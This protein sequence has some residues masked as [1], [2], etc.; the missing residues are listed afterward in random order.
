VPQGTWYAEIHTL[1]AF[2]SNARCCRIAPVKIAILTKG[3]A[4]DPFTAAY[5][6]G[7]PFTDDDQLLVNALR[8]RGHH[9]VAV[10]WDTALEQ[11]QGYDLLL[12][13]S[14][15]DFLFRIDLFRSWLDV[16]L[17][18]ALPI[19]NPIATVRQNLSK[20][21][22]AT[23]QTGGATIIP[24]LFFSPGNHAR[25]AHEARAFG[26]Q[27]VVLKPAVSGGALGAVRHP[28]GASAAIEHAATEILTPG[29]LIV[30]P[31]FEEIGRQGEWSLVFFGSEFSHAV[32]KVPKPG[33]F[34][35]QATYGGSVVRDV[36]SS[37]LIAQAHRAREILASNLPYCRVDGIERAGQL[38]INEVELIDPRLFFATHP[39]AAARFATVLEKR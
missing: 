26:S 4:N 25:V 29:E 32:R 36:P 31:F 16:C 6:S 10:P 35:E 21:Y 12:L 18:H 38:Y 8:A 30:Q 24:T 7:G 3:Q 23:L 2:A 39:P 37:H 33:E 34:R 22:L 15:W 28:I 17:D 11:Q 20:R 27:E 13:R 14:T 5:A 9:V 19:W 1:L